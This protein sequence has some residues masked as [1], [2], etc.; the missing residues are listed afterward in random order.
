MVFSQKLC[1]AHC[2]SS[3][4][5]EKWISLRKNATVVKKPPERERE[6]EINM[7]YLPAKDRYERMV[8][9]RCGNSGIMLPLLSLGLWHNFGNI[10]PWR[11]AKY[12]SY[13]I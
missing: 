3:C 13:G 2:K 4:F 8:Y 6:G 9:R 1:Q 12:A 5:L 11:A 10:T 7:S